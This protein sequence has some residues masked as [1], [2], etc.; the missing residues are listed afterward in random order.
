LPE[1]ETARRTLEPLVVGRRITGF[2]VLR[3]QALRTHKP[4]EAAQILE[5]RT[6]TGLD[7]RGKVLRFALDGGWSL[8]FH[9]ALWGIIRVREQFAPDPQSAAAIHLDDGRVIEFRE[10]ALSNL[11]VDRDADLARVPYLADLGLDAMDK[12][13][14]VARFR[15]T[16]AGKGTVRNLLTD[17][18]RLAGI[19]NLWALEILF[20]AGMRPARKAESL[21][22][23]AWTR[24][25]RATRSVL[26]RGIRAGGEPE[27]A[28]ANGRMGRVRLMVYGR[29][30]QPCR[31]CGTK[32]ATGRVGGRPAFWCPRC[33]R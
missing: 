26:R 2:D 5:G 28:D 17:Q 30:G 29:G 22:D 33:Q 24:F 25:Y 19:G 18:S 16:L 13:L 1:V 12:G 15:E 27:F 7:R 9:F 11:H 23:E 32:I 6:I 4:S 8:R 20:A 31:V 10:L 21:T 14:T 3:P